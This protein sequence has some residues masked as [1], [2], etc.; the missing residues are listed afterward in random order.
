MLIFKFYKDWYLLQHCVICYIL[1]QVKIIGVLYDQP[2]SV[3]E[4]FSASI[5]LAFCIIPDESVDSIPKQLE[6]I[7][8]YIYINIY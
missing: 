6:V 3:L 1:V 7:H 2:L 5:M 8:I 4:K